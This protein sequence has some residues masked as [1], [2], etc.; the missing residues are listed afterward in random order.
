MGLRANTVNGNAGRD[1][2]FDEVDNGVD[3]GS[4]PA[5]VIEVV[6]A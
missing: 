6:A 3:F 4:S 5:E 1:L 2:R